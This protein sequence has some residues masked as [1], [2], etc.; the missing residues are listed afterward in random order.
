MLR[1]ARRTDPGSI[2]AQIAPTAAQK[3][4]RTLRIRA[5]VR[6]AVPPSANSRAKSMFPP[7]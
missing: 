5:R 3:S 1:S 6:P 2:T 7:S 4:A